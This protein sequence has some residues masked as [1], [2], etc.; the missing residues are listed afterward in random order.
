MKKFRNIF[1]L[2]ASVLSLV[3]STIAATA[4]SVNQ[5]A[6]ALESTTTTG[7]KVDCFSQS[8]V[9]SGYTYYD[10]GSC[11]MVINAQAKGLKRTC[12]ANEGTIV[13]VITPGNDPTIN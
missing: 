12:I 8:I 7:N 9:T 10:C 6:Y 1:L 5:N 13:I 11:K 3:G 2:V 4:T